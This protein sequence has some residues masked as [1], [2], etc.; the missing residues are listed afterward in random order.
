MFRNN[1][2]FRKKI[3]YKDG[4]KYLPIGLDINLKLLNWSILRGGILIKNTNFFDDVP[5][6]LSDPL[7][8]T[9]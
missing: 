8:Q 1:D 9:S 6:R 2:I 5:I 7:R 3:I 4:I